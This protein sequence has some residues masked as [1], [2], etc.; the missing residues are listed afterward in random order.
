MKQLLCVALDN[1]TIFY[2]ISS[3]DFIKYCDTK[4]LKLLCVRQHDNRSEAKNE[5]ALQNLLEQ[6]E[7]ISIIVSLVELKNKIA[8]NKGQTLTFQHSKGIVHKL[9]TTPQWN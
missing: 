3:K 9:T 5:M 4:L 6:P 7:L 8:P 2:A 1:L